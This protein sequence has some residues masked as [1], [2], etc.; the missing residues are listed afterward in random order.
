MIFSQQ[1][2]GA[3]TRK[4]VESYK[5]KTNEYSEKISASTGTTGKEQHHRMLEISFFGTVIDAIGSIFNW[6]LCFFFGFLNLDR[7][8]STV[9]S[10]SA[11]ILKKRPHNYCLYLLFVFFRL[12]RPARQLLDGFWPI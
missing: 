6:F 9:P 2:V 10:S 11:D 1:N 7:C 12:L 4:L 3:S 8:V 5:S